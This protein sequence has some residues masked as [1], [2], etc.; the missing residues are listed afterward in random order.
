VID[1]V[2][3][4]RLEDFRDPGGAIYYA[5]SASPRI[6]VGLAGTVT[7]V[8]GLDTEPLARPLGLVR[9]GAPTGGLT[10]SEAI[11][12]Y[13]IAPLHALGI[14][15]QGQRLAIVSDGDR[16]DSSDVL[17]FDRRYGLPKTQPEVVLIDGG[18][19]LSSDSNA[20]E[21]QLGEGDLDTEVAHAI[22]PQAKLLYFSEAFNDNALIGPAINRI[23]AGHAADIVSVSYGLCEPDQNAGDVQNDDNALLAAAAAG[24]TVFVASGD[25]GAYACQAVSASDH[26]LAVSYPGS[27]PY[28]VSVGGTSLAASADGRYIGENAWEDTLSQA[29]GGGGLSRLFH[30]P[31]WQVGPGVQNAY[32]DGMRQ[33]P[34]VAADA[35]PGT[36][37]STVITGSSLETGG[38]SA[39]APLWAASTALIAQ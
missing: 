1:R 30:R 15:G 9:P 4:V 7:G 2:F 23:V 31:N 18:G 24:I 29:G 12:A 16:F 36:G 22:A 26:R 5:P 19:Q 10:P 34:D 33:V 28:V 13:D 35:D 39:A 14:E 37:F 3:G 25:Q 32:S 27:S 17:D 8:G 38:T 20:R 6:P 11:N 21:Q